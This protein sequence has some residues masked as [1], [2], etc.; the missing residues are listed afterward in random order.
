MDVCD[1]QKPIT[2]TPGR[3]DALR[4][5]F[6][7][8][9]GR[10]FDS[11]TLNS[12]TGQIRRTEPEERPS[13]HGDE[14]RFRVKEPNTSTIHHA[15]PVEIIQRTEK[16]TNNSTNIIPLTWE[17]LVGIQEKHQQQQRQTQ[18]I[19]FPFELNEIQQIVGKRIKSLDSIGHYSQVKN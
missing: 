5:L 7:Q 14:I 18:I 16:S 19:L 13:R 11:S 10:T 6:E 9:S 1:V 4:S 15:E 12:P 3:V 8:Q 2:T 17:D